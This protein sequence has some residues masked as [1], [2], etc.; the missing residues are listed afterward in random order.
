MIKKTTTYPE[1]PP[2][3]RAA[4]AAGDRVADDDQAP[5]VAQLFESQVDPAA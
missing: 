1:S 3:A 5:A 4:T 2:R